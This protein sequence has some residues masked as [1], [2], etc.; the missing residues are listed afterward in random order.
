MRGSAPFSSLASAGPVD[1][2]GSVA[3][4]LK[5]RTAP[6]QIAASA[7]RVLAATAVVYACTAASAGAQTP[8]VQ[9]PFA[10][11]FGGGAGNRSTTQS[12]DVRGSLFGVWQDVLEPPADLLRE[13][14]PRFQKSGTFGGAAGSLAYSLQRN[15]RSSGFFISANASAA[16]YSVQ[17]ETVMATYNAASGLTAQLTRRIS[18]AT[19]ASAIYAP[20]YNFGS[21]SARTGNDLIGQL[22]GALPTGSPIG[23]AGFDQTI[24]GAE[25]GLNAVYEPNITLGGNASVNAQLSNRSSLSFTGEYRT[26]RLTETS[27]VSY[28][29][30][31]SAATF[32]H[33][34]TRRLVFRAGYR[35]DISS[36]GEG[37]HFA[38]D[39]YELGLD[40]GDSLTIPLGR[41]TTLSLAPAAS[42]VQWNDDTH[43]VLN[44]SATLTRS[45][46]RTWSASAGYVRDLQFV[47][48]FGEPVLMDSA[49]VTLG[50]TVVS[51]L[52]WMSSAGWSRGRI[53][54]DDDASHFTWY[55]ASTGP[56]IALSRNLALYATYAY[57]SYDVP[58]GASSFPLLTKF[59]RQNVSVGLTAF[60]PVFRTGRT[61]Q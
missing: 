48:G 39:G 50:G 53:G 59:S 15:A 28:D 34:I 22:P 42:V 24:P 40:Y 5:P 18:F 10:G 6:A 32:R 7:G 14:D 21:G 55:T 44:G 3:A 29:S 12:L 9:G 20:F 61:R 46:G 30:W 1:A 54:F 41:R 33:N 8:R 36:Y 57:Y 2:A 49:I 43:F 26:V 13:L 31:A 23:G 27:D 52:R 19:S 56:S 58:S 38:R 17:P 51:R 47:L 35:R 16:D 11:L 60:A 25:F 4:R 37:Q 45:M